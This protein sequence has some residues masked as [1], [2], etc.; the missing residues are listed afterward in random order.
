MIDYL[1]HGYF[2]DIETETAE[3][4]TLTERDREMGIVCYFVK[5]IRDEFILS[6]EKFSKT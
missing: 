6:G 3:I 4:Q 1:L 2:D 5:A